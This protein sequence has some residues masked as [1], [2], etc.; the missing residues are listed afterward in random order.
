MLIFFLLILWPIISFSQSLELIKVIPYSGYSEG[1]DYYHNFLW[2]ALPNEIKKID[3]KNGEIVGRFKPATEYS[4][5]IMWFK[6]LFWNLSFS[7]NGIYKGNIKKNKIEF[8][9]VGI[10][11]EA[12]GW[13]ITNDGINLI[14][15]GHYSSNIYFINPKTFKIE[16]RIK[17]E[18]K[19]IEDLAWDGEN[20]WTSSFTSYRGQ[21]FRLNPQNGKITGIF[22]LPDKESCPVIDGIAFDGR[23]LWISGKYCPSIYCVKL[24]RFDSIV[25]ANP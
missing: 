9:K 25:R 15:T 13:G 5:S 17:A 23:N 12:H 16:R 2:N 19:D 8:K 4:E 7:D 6:G 24:P 1:L 20:I 21:I 3:P 11:P 10:T 22:S 18:V 14:I